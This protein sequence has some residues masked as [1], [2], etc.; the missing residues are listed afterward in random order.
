MTICHIIR[1][2]SPFTLN[3]LLIS[4]IATPTLP[5]KTLEPSENTERELTEA[6]RIAVEKNKPR[7]FR[8]I[9]VVRDEKYHLQNIHIHKRL[10]NA[11]GI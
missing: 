11:I 8:A 3:Q 4:H 7:R 1:R 6:E 2:R 10:R 9:R 5:L